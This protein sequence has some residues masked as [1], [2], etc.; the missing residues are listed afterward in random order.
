MNKYCD[1]IKNLNVREPL[2]TDPQGA[3]L[4]AGSQIQHFPT[5]RKCQI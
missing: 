3:R 2:E 1:E 5:P 4:R